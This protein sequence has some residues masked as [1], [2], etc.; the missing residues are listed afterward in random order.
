MI[1][2][3]KERHEKAA[4]AYKE[5][6]ERAMRKED[7]IIKEAEEA[8]RNAK[9]Q[10]EQA[11]VKLNGYISKHLPVETAEIT[12]ETLNK[13]AIV[14]HIMAD[15]KIKGLM[16][17]EAGGVVQSLCNLLNV[18]AQQKKADKEDSEDEMSNMD[19]DEKEIWGDDDAAKA[20]AI[21]KRRLRRKV[22]KDGLDAPMAEN[23]KNEAGKR[24]APEMTEEEKAAK[25]PKLTAA[26]KEEAAR[27]ALEKATGKTVPA[28]NKA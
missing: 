14:N 16:N 15:E 12:P 5:D 4:N 2:Q 22:P 7:E 11:D 17:L 26:A 9:L 21:A 8:L 6:M 27:L 24:G 13:E 20:E 3:E 10:Y 25:D 28:G 1:K 23:V 18:I 19:L